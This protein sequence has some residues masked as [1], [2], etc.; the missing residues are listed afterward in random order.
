MR[1]DSGILHPV[2]LAALIALVVNDHV[3]KPCYPGWVTGKLSDAAG[4]IVFPLLA[5]AV[6]RPVVPRVRP[7]RVLAAAIAATMLGFLAIKLWPPATA[8]CA[9]VRAITRSVWAAC[10]CS[11]GIQRA[12]L[13]D[14]IHR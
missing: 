3:G 4:L 7:A 6:A 8:A 9:R 2:A 13:P 10:P 5:C 12:S 14:S 11:Q 1:R